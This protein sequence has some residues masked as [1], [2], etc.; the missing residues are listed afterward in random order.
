MRPADN[1]NETIKKLKLKASTDLD[2]RV[3][4]DISRALA[5]SD[6]AKSPVTQPNIWRTIMNSRI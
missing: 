6:R 5:A 4:G 3:H 2:R 1:I